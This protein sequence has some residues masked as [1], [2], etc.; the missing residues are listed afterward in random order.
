MSVLHAIILSL[1]QGASELFPV[2]SL[3]HSVLI[4]ALLGWNEGRAGDP[5]NAGFVAFLVVLHLGTA[6]A[7][8]VFFW[9]DWV[10]VLRALGRSLARRS[11]SDDP[12]ERLGWLVIIGSIPAGVLG[13][14]FQ[15]SLESLFDKAIPVSIFLILN[16]IMM[17]VG[18]RLR[19]RQTTTAATAATA[20]TVPA[21][22]GG[23]SS[24]LLSD[25]RKGIADLGV[26]GGI[27]VGVMQALALL[28]GFSRSGA[29]ITGGLLVGLRHEDAARYSFMLAT[30]LIVAANLLKAPEIF[31]PGANIGLGIS[32]LGFVIAGV[33]A[34]LVIRFLMRYFETERLD[35]FG[36]YCIAF[37]IFCLT[38]FT[39]RGV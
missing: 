35:P 25:G 22:P 37:G 23:G 39:V 29:S 24:V 31:K 34:Y 12:D 19:R 1:L 36:W 27:G 9:R 33:T 26:S 21:V 17:L 14:L 13:V 15:K 28:P 38:V 32:A 10:R 2:S 30:P 7:L 4:P 18:E 11:L 6:I 5:G 20:A 16:G 3:G 8:L